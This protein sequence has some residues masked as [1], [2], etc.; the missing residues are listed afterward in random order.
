VDRTIPIILGP[1]SVPFDLAIVFPRF[2]RMG[3]TLI[4]YL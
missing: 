4:E 3:E 2:I 1:P